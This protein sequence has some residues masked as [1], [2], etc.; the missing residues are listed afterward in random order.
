M[1][2]P[3]QSRHSRAAFDT[4]DA[5]PQQQ[6]AQRRQERSGQRT[7]QQP[8]NPRQRQRYAE[9]RQCQVEQCH[10]A[11]APAGDDETLVEVRA[12]RGKDVFAAAPATEDR[13]GRVEDKGPEQQL[14]VRD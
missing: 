4:P 13:E 7:A 3:A 8:A 5:P 12:V 1:H 11:V 14:F 9:Q 6:G 10:A 2:R